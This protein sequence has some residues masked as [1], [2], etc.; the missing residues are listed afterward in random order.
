MCIVWETMSFFFYTTTKSGFSSEK[1]LTAEWTGIW[2]VHRALL[3]I[4]CPVL[5]QQSKTKITTSEQYISSYKQ[6]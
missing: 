5:D 3:P 6:V 4:Y 2:G 1:T